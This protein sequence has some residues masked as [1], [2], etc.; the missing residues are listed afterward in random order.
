MVFVELRFVGCWVQCIACFIKLSFVSLMHPELD[1]T[2]ILVCQRF[3][4]YV[5]DY[6]NK[7]GYR[8]TARELLHEA[9]LPEDSRPPIDAKQGLLFE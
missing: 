2:H 7:R 6:C 4:I 1:L 9:R 5:Y 3:N 8:K